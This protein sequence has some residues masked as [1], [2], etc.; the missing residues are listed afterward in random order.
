[1]LTRRLSL[2][3][4]ALLAAGC[5]SSGVAN[6]DSGD[7]VREL[8]NR[9]LEPSGVVI[10]YEINE[11]MRAWAHRLVPEETA[12]EKRLET[13]LAGLVDPDKLK[14]VYEPRHTAT[15][16]EVFETRRANC[17][18][19]TSLFVGMAREIGVPAFYLDVDDVERFEK[20][21]DLVVVSGHVSAGYGTSSE[22]KILDFSAA[23][24]PGY[25]H[26]HRISDMT[27]IAL[28]HSNRG[29]ELLRTGKQDEAL[30]WLQKAVTIDPELPGAWI[31]YGVALRRSGD[32]TRAEEAYRRALEID[33]LAVSAYQN[34]AALLRHQ[35][36]P[37]EAE[38]LLAL[39]GTLGS[40]NPF[41]YLAL[42]DLSLAH[43]RIDEARR[44]YK[45]AMRLYRDNAEPYAAM[46]IAALASG[47]A[48]EAH[49]WMRKA[50]AIDQENQRV[51]VLV[52]RL[53]G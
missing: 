26:V 15:A 32:L 33:P 9:G 27:A 36:K 14:V 52:A 50:V 29:G 45:R 35:G 44:F 51:K 47:D 42:G 18:A 23:P 40:R 24:E 4:A 20:E 8:R 3:T 39:S 16:Q 49:R 5:T 46:G 19:F 48:G 34:L 38:D 41:I 13:L 11:E 25:K 53:G 43:G 28:F 2:L 10:P 6:L 30:P 7:V 12:P 1:M 22:L 37:Q 17:L 21:G 31:N